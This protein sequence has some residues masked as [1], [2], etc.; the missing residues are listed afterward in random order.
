MIKNQVT[1]HLPEKGYKGTSQARKFEWIIDE[2]ENVG[3]SNL[4]PTPTEFLNGALGGCIAI[5]LRMYAQRKNWDTGEISVE[6]YT[7]EN[8]H[9]QIEIHKKIHY[10]NIQN[11]TPEQVE[12]LNII[13]TKCP[14]SKILQQATP[15]ILD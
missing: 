1:F 15:V 7:T 2:P 4:A 6:I 10:R 13:A 11:L 3:G 12:R 5:T 14:V 8:E 9:K